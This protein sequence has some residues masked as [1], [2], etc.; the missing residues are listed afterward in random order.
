MFARVAVLRLTSDVT[1]ADIVRA[2]FGGFAAYLWSLVYWLSATIGCIAVALA[3]V[4][5]LAWFVPRLAE[6]G[7]TLAALSPRCGS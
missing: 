2:E 3:A 7:W 4:G 1:L 5:Y 6:P